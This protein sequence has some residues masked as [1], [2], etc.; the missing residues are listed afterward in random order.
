MGSEGGRYMRLSYKYDEMLL[1]EL[2]E[3]GFRLSHF[4]V[5]EDVTPHGLTCIHEIYTVQH[6]VTKDI[7]YVRKADGYVV[8]MKKL[9]S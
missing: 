5:E 9:N 7:Y 6:D 2:D 8:E 4:Q 3:F 1:K